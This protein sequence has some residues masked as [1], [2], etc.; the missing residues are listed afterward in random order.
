MSF[1]A[2]L[3]AALALALLACGGGDGGPAAPV[4]Q[5][6]LS[7]IEVNPRAL[8]LQVGQTAQLEVVLVGPGASSGQAVIGYAAGSSAVLVSTT[9]LVTALQA[10]F[11]TIVIQA[12]HPATS[13]FA[14]AFVT[15]QVPVSVS[16]ASGSVGTAADR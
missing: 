16:A 14:P 7:A 12:S 15:A 1:R 4:R 11:A 5:P 2:V 13:A 10:G 8:S 6:A 3:I 9:G